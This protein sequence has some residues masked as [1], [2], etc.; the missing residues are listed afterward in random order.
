MAGRRPVLLLPGR[1]DAA[2]AVWLTIGRRVLRRL[3]GAA[4][5]DERLTRARLT[6]KI[7]SAPGLAELIAVRIEADGAPPIASGYL[8]MA[9]L[10]I[11]DGWILV[12]A[13][14]EGYPAGTRVTVRPLP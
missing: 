1:I 4:A 12:P 9:T 2:L 14:S 6:R 5:E 3:S 8:S 11:S 10:A 13:E 7:A